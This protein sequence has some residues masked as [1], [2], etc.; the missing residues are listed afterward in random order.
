MEVREAWA[1][2]ARKVEALGLRCASGES[3]RRLALA[4]EAGR[5][6][7]RDIGGSDPERM[8]PPLVERYVRRLFSGDGTSVAVECVSDAAALR[9][10]YPLFSAVNRCASGTFSL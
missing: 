5:V 4:L 8:A 7:G 10:Q 9:S 6:A 3:V 1:E 2:K